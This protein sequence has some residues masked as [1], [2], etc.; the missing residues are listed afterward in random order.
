MDI[1]AVELVIVVILPTNNP[2]P[3]PTPPAT[4]SAPVI[5]ELTAVTL[6]M[7]KIPEYGLAIK[8]ALPVNPITP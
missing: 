3:M 7:V 8:P 1:A 2:P 5:V 6:V 4:C